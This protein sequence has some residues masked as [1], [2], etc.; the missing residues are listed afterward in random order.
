MT[1]YDTFANKHPTTFLHNRLTGEY[2]CMDYC[3]KAGEIPAVDGET[4]VLAA[5]MIHDTIVAGCVAS[6]GRTAKIKASEKALDML[7]KSSQAEFRETFK[8]NCP[9]AE[10]PPEADLGTAI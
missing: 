3:L 1:V 9:H 2:G 8:C 10:N 5:V 4:R 7:D 6:S